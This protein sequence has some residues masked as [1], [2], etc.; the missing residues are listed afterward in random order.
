MTVYRTIIMSHF[1]LDNLIWFG[2]IA[3]SLARTGWLPSS[4]DRMRSGHSRPGDE[5]DAEADH[6]N[7]DNL[8]DVNGLP[9]EHDA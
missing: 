7:A 3:Y 2:L 9:Q 6:D 8:Q 4:A 1:F 5:A